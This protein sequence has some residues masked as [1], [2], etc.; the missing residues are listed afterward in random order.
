MPG[1]TNLVLGANDR[2]GEVAGSLKGD[3]TAGQDEA[4]V[5]PSD[6][7][8]DDLF[9]N[10]GVPD[11]DA[12]WTPNLSCWREGLLKKAQALHGIALDERFHVGKQHSKEGFVFHVV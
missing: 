5:G 1:R 3:Q 9:G 10:L 11:E 4:T 12:L 7:E 8:P 2:C 6:L